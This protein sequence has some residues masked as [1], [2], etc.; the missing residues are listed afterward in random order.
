MKSIYNL[1]PTSL[2]LLLL[3]F[4]VTTGYAQELTIKIAGSSTVYPLTNAVVSLYK[5]SPNALPVQLDVTG[6]G[7]GFKRFCAGETHFNNS[8]RR[9]IASELAQLEK[10]GIEWY[11]LTVAQDAIAIVVNRENSFVNDISLDELRLIWRKNSTVNSWN[12]LRASWPSEEIHLYGPGKNS[13][14][15]DYF[16]EVLFGNSSEMRDDYEMSEDDDELE[17]DVEKD[18]FALSFFGV[19]YVERN[20]NQVKLVGVRDKEIIVF[21]NYAS[22]QTRTYPIS[23]A[24]YL[25]INLTELKKSRKMQDFVQ[26]YIKS[27]T[28]LAKAAGYIPLDARLY[29]KSLNELVFAQP[30]LAR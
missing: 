29:R 12:D 1:V 19:V 27:A 15:R 18:K 16:A 8:S 25:H 20:N 3:A 9:P 17:S 14:T 28:T 6:T 10:N 30:Q 5:R 23:R 24:L 13:G 11:E 26:L 2:F 21:P 4:S 22:I 7:G